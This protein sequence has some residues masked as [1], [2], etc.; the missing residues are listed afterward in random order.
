MRRTDFCRLILS[1]QHPRSA[2]SRLRPNACAPGAS[3]GMPD[4]TSVP[5][6]FGDPHP[7][8]LVAPTRALSSRR[9]ACGPT[10]D[11]LS[12]PPPCPCRSRVTCRAE[13]AEAASIL[14]R[15]NGARAMTTMSAFHRA[16]TVT[17]Q[18]PLG[19]P[20]RVFPVPRSLAAA[21]EVRDV[22]ASGGFPCGLLPGLGPRPRAPLPPGIA[23]L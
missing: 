3:E 20:D 19:R 21:E 14:A 22:F 13:A 12:P 6:R 15:V 8:T 10:S 9:G 18:H 23:L 5:F 7:C 17:L 11:T 4:S 16:N 1:Y 2:G